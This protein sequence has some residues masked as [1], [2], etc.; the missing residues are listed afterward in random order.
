MV[1]RNYIQVW[2]YT[3]ATEMPS[4]ALVLALVPLQN[5]L[6]HFKIFQ[7]KCP[8]QTENSLGPLKAET[9]GLYLQPEPRLPKTSVQLLLYKTDYY[10]FIIN[11]VLFQ[12]SK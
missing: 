5:F 4:V 2:N 7:W 9:Q 11:L 10:F 12:Y 8:L 1:D 6:L 3:K